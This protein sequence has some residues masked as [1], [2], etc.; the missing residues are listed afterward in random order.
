M[1]LNRS[2]ANATIATLAAE[3]YA[4]KK[5]KSIAAGRLMYMRSQER[6][7][8][9]REAMIEIL[10]GKLHKQHGEVDVSAVYDEIERQ[11]RVEV[12][13]RT[14]RK[15]H[16]RTTV[17]RTKSKRGKRVRRTRAKTVKVE[18]EAS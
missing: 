9:V 13:R 18:T 4:L 8:R 16:R 10:L 12:E 17:V 5:R 3:N 2:L 1:H 15:R 6:D 11:A 7:L 14:P